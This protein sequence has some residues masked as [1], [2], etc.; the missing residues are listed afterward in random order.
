MSDTSLPDGIPEW[1]AELRECYG[2][3]EA[4]VPSDAL[5]KL[6]AVAAH[7]V[8]RPAAPLTTYVAGFVAGARGGEA[9]DIDALIAELAERASGWENATDVDEL[10]AELTEAT[11]AG[12]PSQRDGEAAPDNEAR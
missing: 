2:L 4:Q 1:I 11:D 8:T 9:A 10:V 6:A 3:T 7:S 12:D 5:L